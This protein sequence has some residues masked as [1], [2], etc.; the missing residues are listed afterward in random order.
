MISNGQASLLDVFVCNGSRCCAGS[1]SRDPRQV[2]CGTGAADV[3]NF[4]LGNE[5]RQQDHRNG[6]SIHSALPRLG[7]LLR[8]RSLRKPKGSYSRAVPE[9]ELRAGCT[10]SSQVSFRTLGIRSAKVKQVQL[11]H[12]PADITGA[13][14]EIP[15]DKVLLKNKNKIVFSVCNVFF[16]G[17]TRAGFQRF[18]AVA[19]R[20]AVIVNLVPEQ[21]R[22][23]Y[24]KAMYASN[25]LILSRRCYFSTPPR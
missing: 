20:K 10:T 22:I 17:E 6:D 7:R 5:R 18:H 14:T 9:G 15:G 13:T 25:P 8:G 21:V 24:D 4:V 11:G 3:C 16:A 2:G 19:V 23:P 1:A 12:P